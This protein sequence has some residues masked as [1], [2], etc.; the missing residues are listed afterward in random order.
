M[1][2]EQN[3]SAHQSQLS[4]LTNDG[5]N[6]NYGEWETRAFHS[7]WTWDL[8]K[9]IK[10]K[11]STPPVIPPLTERHTYHGVDNQNQLATV[12]IPGNCA[13]HETAIR[14]AEPWMTANNLCLSKIIH[15][16]PTQHLHLVK[17][18]VYAKEVWES[19]HMVF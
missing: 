11:Q 6:N 14:N 4:K 12:H 9:Y 2:D 7:F 10:G 16:V 18:T 3:D 15:T 13:E 17:H 1:A 5:I 19:L 8:W